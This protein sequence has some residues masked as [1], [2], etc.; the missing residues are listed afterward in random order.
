MNDHEEY[1]P[2]L[3]FFITFFFGGFGVHHFIRRH[4]G[5]GVLYFFTFGVMG[6]GWLIDTIRAFVAM[7]KTSSEPQTGGHRCRQCGRRIEPNRDSSLCRHCEEQM[8]QDYLQISKH[9]TRVIDEV[10]K[11]QPHLED[12]LRRFDI[13][14]KDV[15]QMWDLAQDIDV[16]PPFHQSDLR[17]AMDRKFAEAVS[18]RISMA[19]EKSQITMDTLKLKQEL[20]ALTEEL[21]DC[22]Y[23]F[24]KYA[25]LIAPMIEKAKETLNKI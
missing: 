24:P 16:E 15:E 20:M 3:M 17:K 13:L 8:E 7:F 12:Y 21:I 6:I 2:I 22:K 18:T 11:G 14:N 9:F 25:E 5:L 23:H 4:Y 10:E 19:L 1:D